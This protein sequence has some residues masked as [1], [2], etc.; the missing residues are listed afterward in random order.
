MNVLCNVI[1]YIY[2][3]AQYQTL[4]LTLAAFTL[5]TFESKLHVDLHSSLNIV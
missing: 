5:Y 3:Y 4:T 2:I 1:P